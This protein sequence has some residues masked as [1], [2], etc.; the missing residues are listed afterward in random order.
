MLDEGGV[1]LA[2]DRANLAEVTEWL[3]SA[4]HDRLGLAIARGEVRPWL[5]GHAHH[6]HVAMQAVSNAPGPLPRAKPVLLDVGVTANRGEVDAALEALLVSSADMSYLVNGWRAVS[7]EHL[8]GS[9]ST[10]TTTHAS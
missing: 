1:L 3:Y 7:L 8:R 2:V 4:K 6:E 10:L 5:I 9:C